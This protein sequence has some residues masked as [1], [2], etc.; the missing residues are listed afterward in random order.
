MSS[1]QPVMMRLAKSLHFWVI[2]EGLEGFFAVWHYV[3]M[4]DGNIQ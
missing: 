4:M 1:G 2:D 3:S